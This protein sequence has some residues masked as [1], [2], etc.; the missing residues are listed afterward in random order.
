MNDV[1]QAVKESTKF[2]VDFILCYS[3]LNQ[4]N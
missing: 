4:I 2:D 3:N 1:Y